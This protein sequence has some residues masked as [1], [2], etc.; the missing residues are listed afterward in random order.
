MA[1]NINIACAVGGCTNP[2]I[3]QCRTCGRYYCTN[4]NKD[5]LCLECAAKKEDEEL[6]KDYLQTAER[7]RRE[8]DKGYTFTKGVMGMAIGTFACV[9]A[10][11]LFLFITE[12]D[13][14]GI[15]CSIILFGGLIGHYLLSLKTQSSRRIKRAL[16]KATETDKSKP[17]FL[18]FYK[19][20]DNKKPKDEII[21]ALN[22]GKKFAIDFG[23]E[24]AKEVF[25]DK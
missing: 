12:E 24:T 5:S 15:L 8:T 19:A 6:F 3:G 11:T 13:L 23:R 4:H 1:T 21:E 10:F 18:E 7:I 2:V 14:Q 16:Q 25:K 20:W 22:I 9:G 17:G